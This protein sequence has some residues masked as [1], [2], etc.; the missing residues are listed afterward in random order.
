MADSAQG[1]DDR[2]A[3]GMGWM[4]RPPEERSAKDVPKV[5]EDS[6]VSCNF[7]LLF[8]FFLLLMCQIC[9]SAL[10]EK[11]D[12]PVAK[13]S[14]REL[15]PYWKA[16]DGSGLPPADDQKAL[17]LGAHGMVGDGG[18]SWRRKALKRAREQAEREGKPLEDVCGECMIF[19]YNS[20]LLSLIAGCC[21]E[22]GIGFKLDGAQR[23]RWC[24]QS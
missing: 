23:P 4:S 6:D 22:V 9:C 14:A 5:V 24:G 15:N 3:A 13:I 1:Q 20:L 17:S 21:R 7:Q 2:E 19:L 11:Q 10:Q 16:G 8:S 18:A 12:P